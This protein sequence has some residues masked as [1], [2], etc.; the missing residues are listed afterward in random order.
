MSKWGSGP[1]IKY[2]QT[3]VKKTSDSKDFNPSRPSSRSR[4]Q[5]KKEIH[6][7]VKTYALKVE[8][9]PERERKFPNIV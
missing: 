6:C 7:L 2:K 4:D 5:M 9:L 1:E 8:T 3:V